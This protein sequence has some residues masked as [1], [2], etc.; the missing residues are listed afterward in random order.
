MG[1]KKPLRDIVVVLPGI[2]GSVLQRD[3][4]DVWA[5]SGRAAW[6]ALTSRGRS[7]RDLELRPGVDDGITASSVMPSAHV[8]PGLVRIDGYSHLIRMVEETFDVVR[9]GHG[10]ALNLVAFPYD[11]RR[12]NREAARRL[13]SML[14]ELLPAW[15]AHERG[16]MDA[17][18]IVIGHSM[19]GLVARYWI[20]CLDG[21]RDCR[22]LIT[23]GT[24]HRGSPNAIG[25]LANGYKKLFMDLTVAMRSFPSVHQLLPRYRALMV[26]GEARRIAETNGVPG[27]DPELARD[28]LRFHEEIER[29]VKDNDREHGKRRYVL[30]PFVGVRQPTIQ[31]ALLEQ[32]RVSVTGD[33]PPGIDALLADGDGTV[34]RVSAIPI[35]L[36]DDYRDTFIAERHGSLQTNEN[37]LADVRE[38]LV[39]LQVRGLAEVRSAADPS[40][41]T[42]PALAIE[43][44]DAY[45]GEEPVRI[46]AWVTGSATPPGHVRA[47]VTSVDPPAGTAPREVPFT[48]VDNR[49]RLEL[50]DL[51]AGLHR[52][53]VSIVGGGPWAPPPVHELFEV[54]PGEAPG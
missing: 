30:L 52:V 17:K 12:D 42:H 40:A 53:E 38:R 2:T 9:D 32:E 27:V 47:L 43:V 31:S 49:W 54:V 33:L 37:V 5:V 23:F 45:V 8:V 20:E 29:G 3:G 26:D 50:D 4:E 28:G 25:Y 44:D 16:S 6:N 39:Q 34:P 24:P 41:A 35:E 10:R 1:G 36:S 15:R 22:A 21:W 11:W 18:V 19:G 13:A 14:A 48:R 51:P 46:D 7:L